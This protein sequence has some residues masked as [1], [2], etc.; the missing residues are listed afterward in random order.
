VTNERKSSS[1]LEEPDVTFI[2]S[3]DACGHYWS[4][5]TDFRLSFVIPTLTPIA[6]MAKDQ[7]ALRLLLETAAFM[8]NDVGFAESDLSAT[9]ADS[10][11][12]VLLDQEMA[13]DMGADALSRAMARIDGLDRAD[14]RAALAAKAAGQG[15][16]EILGLPSPVRDAALNALE[17]SGWKFGGRGLKR[18]AL[19]EPTVDG[20]YIELLRIMPG[21]GSPRH[22]HEGD[23]V[24]LVLCGA[25]HD[26]H[27]R[28][29]AGDIAVAHRGLVHQ[30]VAEAG[31]VCFALAVNVGD[32]RF[33]GA[34]GLVQRAL[35]LH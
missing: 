3:F 26:G 11:G 15:L 32:L 10:I 2:W 34:V 8:R 33:S 27:Q 1:D 25:Y 18:L 7:P 35:R 23:E 30:P 19:A 29:G 28:Y 21:S 13:V 16:T 9:E 4:Q 12:G 6:E 14:H 20:V 24:T 17:H 31:Q 22:D 5:P